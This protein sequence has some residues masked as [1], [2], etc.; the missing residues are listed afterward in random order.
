MN[1]ETIAIGKY[2]WSNPSGTITF[3]IAQA[4]TQIKLTES[5]IA[6]FYNLAVDLIRTRQPQIAEAIAS[7]E[8]EYFV[9]KMIE[10]QPETSSEVPF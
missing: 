1:I 2:S 7:A 8:S 4:K 3:E 9:P 5:E 6:Q 10:L